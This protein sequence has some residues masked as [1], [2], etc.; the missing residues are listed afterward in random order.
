MP[1]FFTGK[2]IGGIRI[3]QKP[4]L[5]ITVF[6]EALEIEYIP[7]PLRGGR[8]QG[9][10]Q[11]A[12]SS[13]EPGTDYLHDHTRYRSYFGMWIAVQRQR[14]KNPHLRYERLSENIYRI[15][16]DP[17]AKISKAPSSKAPNP[18]KRPTPKKTPA[19]RLS[20]SELRLALQYLPRGIQAEIGLEIG[21]SREYVRQV[22]QG[23]SKTGTSGKS[24][25]IW[26]V[27]HRKVVERYA[28]VRMFEQIIEALKQGRPVKAK[29][30][31]YRFRLIV[32][33]LQKLGVRFKVERD[34]K[35]SCPLSHMLI[36]VC[37]KA[38]SA[39]AAPNSN[40]Q[41]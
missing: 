5:L 12:I 8:P 16:L 18:P 14:F 23:E 6:M 27:L 25:Q 39:A 41:D 29:I 13:L 11:N 35:R 20:Q 26:T 3:A 30:V 15:F 9:P 40:P 2:L 34:R 28:E 38:S 24:F 4:K 21:V 33:Q 37:K 19:P 7:R 1:P 10:A 36:P 32:H 31:L 17:K 22:I